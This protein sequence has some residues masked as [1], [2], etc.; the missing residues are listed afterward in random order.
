MSRC[1]QSRYTRSGCVRCEY[2]KFVCARSGCVIWL[3]LCVGVRGGYVH[4]LWVSVLCNGIHSVVAG[5]NIL[6]ND[7]SYDNMCTIF[8]TL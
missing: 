5:A 8:D 2:I 7:S 6:I 3:W 4:E 1:I